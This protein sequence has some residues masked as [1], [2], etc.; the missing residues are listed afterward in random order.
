MKKHN[1]RGAGRKP[2]YSEP[3]KAVAFKVPESIVDSFR[4]KA[5]DL[6]EELVKV[7]AK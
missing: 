5:K 2:K 7:K 3:T 4:A 6:I 1:E